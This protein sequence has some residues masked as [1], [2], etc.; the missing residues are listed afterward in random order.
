[1]G[2]AHTE[3][4]HP[5]PWL[6]QDGFTGGLQQPVQFFLRDGRYLRPCH[7]TRFDSSQPTIMDLQ[8]GIACS[9]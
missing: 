1:M 8:R 5:L 9:E 6:G 4:V 2:L 7:M 3:Q